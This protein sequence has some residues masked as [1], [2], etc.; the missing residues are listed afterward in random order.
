VVTLTGLVNNNSD[1]S[2]AASLALQQRGVKTV[3]DNLALSP[4]PLVT[5]I[6]GVLGALTRAVEGSQTPDVLTGTPTQSPSIKTVTVP[7][8]QPWTATGVFLNAGAVVKISASGG[9][10]FSIGS[11]SRPPTGDPPDC[12]TVANGP[13]GWRAAPYVANQ[14]PCNSLLARVGDK[15][16]IFYVGAGTTF[17]AATPGQL[18]LGVNDNVFGD[19]SGSWTAVITVLSGSAAPPS[20][21]ATSPLPLAARGPTAPYIIS[22]TPIASQQTQA[23]TITGRG[24]GSYPAYTDRDIPYLAIRDKTAG[25]AAGRVTRGNI[26]AVTLSV[27]RW[28]DTE[29]VVTGFGGAYGGGW[30]LRDGDQVEV[31]V[32]NAQTGAGAATYELTVGGSPYSSTPARWLGFANETGPQDRETEL[33]RNCGDFTR[34]Y[35]PGDAGNSFADLCGH[36]G[37][38]C[39]RVCDWEGTSFS[40][41]AV[42]LGG[43]RNG[44]RIALCSPASTAIASDIRSVDFR[45]FSYESNCWK[46]VDPGFGKVIRATEGSW[47]KGPLEA[48]NLSFEVVKVFYGDVKG[49]GKVEAVVRTLCQPPANWDY[50]ELF[51]FEMSGATPK[52]LAR[53]TPGEGLADHGP[54]YDV[55]KAGGGELDVSYQETGEKGFGACPEWTV[56]ERFRWNG[57]RFVSTG[58]SRR[59]NDCSR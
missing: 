12:L 46:K 57:N 30:Q 59:K 17:K 16:I 9:V 55:V 4:S 33:R 7:G 25:W 35:V 44:T 15:G 20:L 48:W 53:L 51:V 24:F 27:T 37:K 28:T 54:G 1:R 41:S 56:T 3:V 50:E 38:T 40:C 23:I 21:Q 13:Y 49:D 14:L 8:N 29:I 45:N 19:N 43:R 36:E 42:S 34:V 52:L 11:E 26:D 22:V 32:W 10:S 2:T 5:G 47:K 58:Q 18:Y 6:V 39:E 31:A